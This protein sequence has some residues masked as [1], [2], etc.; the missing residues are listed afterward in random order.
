M[1]FIRISAVIRWLF[2][3]YS[4]VFLCIPFI[5]IYSSLFPHISCSP[6]PV[7]R[8]VSHSFVWFVCSLD[9]SVGQPIVYLSK[10]LST[11]TRCLF[12]VLQ[13]EELEARGHLTDEDRETIQFL[14]A[15]EDLYDQRS[16]ER[17][18]AELDANTER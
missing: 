2:P 5:P 6:V 14:H 13:C 4:P 8:L 17:A 3:L 7:G 16:F 10:L 15:A 1:H 12:D 9:R 11:G 18:K